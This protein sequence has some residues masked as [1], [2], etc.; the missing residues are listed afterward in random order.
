M[1][2]ADLTVA[3]VA[4]VVKTRAD[5][6]KVDPAVLTLKSAKVTKADLLKAADPVAPA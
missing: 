6:L 4:K 5:L 2:T 3:K 1:A